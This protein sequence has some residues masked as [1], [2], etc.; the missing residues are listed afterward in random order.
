MTEGNRHWRPSR[1]S[2]IA[3]AIVVAG[4]WLS[5]VSWWFFLLVG[6]GTF[7][8]GLLR[9]FGVL[10]DR[11]D[12]FAI[13]SNLGSE[14]TGWTALL[15]HPLIA[16][17]F[18]GLAWLSRRWPRIAGLLLL[19]LAVFFF[20]FFGFFDKERMASLLMGKAQEDAF[21]DGS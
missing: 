7:G 20:R 15:L 6:I 17:P 3:G 14:W 10:N 9:E 16:L 11:D 4:F 8:P 21:A 2:L 18:F 19:A 5:S 13:L 1:T 12:V